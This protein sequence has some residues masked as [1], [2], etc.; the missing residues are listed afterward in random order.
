MLFGVLLMS[1]GPTIVA[2]SGVATLN[3]EAFGTQQGCLA[4]YNVPGFDPAT[5]ATC[6]PAGP[7]TKTA[8]VRCNADGSGTINYTVTGV[9]AGP[10]PGQ[11][12]ETGVI[13]FGPRVL[14]GVP[15]PGPYGDTPIVGF[16]ATFHIDSGTTD[17]DGRKY[18]PPGTASGSGSCAPD[19]GG[20]PRQSQAFFVPAFE[21]TVQ[22]ATGG[23]YHDEGNVIV[24]TY[25]ITAA[26]QNPYV[27]PV[28]TT[29]VGHFELFSSANLFAMPLDGDG[30]GVG[31]AIDNCPTTPN[32]DQANV[33]GDGI[34]DAC[35]DSD[36]DGVVDAVDNCRLTANPT[37]SDVDGD[38]IG[39]AC[40]DSDSDGVFDSTDNCR[41]TANPTQ[42]DRDGDG[43]G[44]ACDDSDGDRFFDNV[45]NCPTVPNPDQADADNDGEG[46]ACEAPP[47]TLDACKNDRWMTYGIFKNQGDCVSFVATKGKNGPG[48][49]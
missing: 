1:F 14:P 3:G 27:Q 24:S 4:P 17:V 46:N 40:D 20:Y 39:D 26:N 44:D 18:L 7:S 21:A 36:S 42:A 6:V 49:N 9:A 22:P 16:E 37:Q 38:G 13:T 41:V 8:Q 2:Q 31:D 25:A 43:I 19:A 47:T 34:G 12:S 32:A 11:Y 30:D 35:D 15:R 45:D 28:V 29:T 23:E 48:G 10:Y 33:D 5:P